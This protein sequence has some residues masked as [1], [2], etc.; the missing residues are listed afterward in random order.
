MGRERIGR[1]GDPTGVLLRE[2]QHRSSI[3]PSGSRGGSS[4]NEEPAQ[5]RK[6]QAVSDVAMRFGAESRAVRPPSTRKLQ[7]TDREHPIDLGE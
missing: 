7:S 5:N 2:R 3:R 4:Y 1:V 6:T